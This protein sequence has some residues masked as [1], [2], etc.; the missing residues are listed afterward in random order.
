M[1]GLFPAFGNRRRL[2]SA[3]F[4]LAPGRRLDVVVIA[5]EWGHGK[6]R[7]MLLDYTFAVRRSESDPELLVIGKAYSGLTD[8]EMVE[9]DVVRRTSHG[10]AQSPRVRGGTE[11]GHR[12]RLRCRATEYAPPE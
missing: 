2:F 1:I 4:V 8:A 12:S 10:D 3:R 7:A 9:M 11:R 6:R 5:V